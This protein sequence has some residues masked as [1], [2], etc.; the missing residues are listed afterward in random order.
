MITGHVKSMMNLSL[1]RCKMLKIPSPDIND[2][3]IPILFFFVL[4]T[5]RKVKEARTTVYGWRQ[6]L[7]MRELQSENKDRWNSSR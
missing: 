7:K 5:S 2:K 6:A 1:V 3:L 4:P